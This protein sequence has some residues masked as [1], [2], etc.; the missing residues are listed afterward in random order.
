[1]PKVNKGE[2]VVVILSPQEVRDSIEHK[3]WCA[4]VDDDPSIVV[5]M[6]PIIVQDNEGGYRVQYSRLAR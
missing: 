5:K 2:T 3:A 4:A 6:P 1:M